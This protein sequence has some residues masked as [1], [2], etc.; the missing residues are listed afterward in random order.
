MWEMLNNEGLNGKEK[1]AL[2]LKFDAV[3]GLDLKRVKEEKIPAE[4]IKLAEERLKARN[5]KDWQKADELRQKIAVLGYI[6]GDTK[7]GYEVKKE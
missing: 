6:V 3:L 5:T 1:Y 7:E 2:L 4:V